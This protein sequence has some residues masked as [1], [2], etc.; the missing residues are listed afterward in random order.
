MRNFRRH[1]NWWGWR[2][3]RVMNSFARNKNTI[4]SMMMKFMPG[5]R[6]YSRLQATQTFLMIEKRQLYAGDGD[7]QNVLQTK[8]IFKVILRQTKHCCCYFFVLLTHKIKK[9]TITKDI[10]KSS[11]AS[12]FDQCVCVCYRIHVVTRRDEQQHELWAPKTKIM[13]EISI[14]NHLTHF[15]FF[16]SISPSVSFTQ[17]ALAKRNNNS[18]TFCILFILFSAKSSGIVEI[19]LSRTIS[20]THLTALFDNIKRMRRDVSA[21]TALLT[22]QSEFERIREWYYC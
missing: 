20:A 1:F 8:L 7:I 18:S 5:G 15:T 4:I 14:Y 9:K 19:N 22:E 13:L 2:C 21:S 11:F 6:H 17:F 12:L 16:F 3:E 10:L